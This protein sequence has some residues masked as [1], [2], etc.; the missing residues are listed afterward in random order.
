VR[1]AAGP[2]AWQEYRRDDLRAGDLLE[3]PAIVVEYSATTLLPPGWRLE[4]THAGQLLI[5]RT[6]D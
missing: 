6:T 3:T 2:Q 5:E 4:V 1:T